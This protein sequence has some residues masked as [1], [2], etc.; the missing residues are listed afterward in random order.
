VRDLLAAAVEAAHPTLGICLGHQLL[1]VACG[2][3]VARN[4]AGK[5]IGVLPVGLRPAAGIDHLFGSVSG[6]TRPE[7]VQWNDDIVVRV[8]PGAI[9]LATT[10]DGVPQALRVGEAAWGVQFHPEVDVA[11]VTAWAEEHGPPTPAQ[12]AALADIA[13]RSAATAATGRALATGFV[14]VATEATRMVG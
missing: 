4:P 11:I 3:S 5:Q 12:A 9:R 6:G 1:A 2:G 14:A 8:P 10:S 7:S 13:A